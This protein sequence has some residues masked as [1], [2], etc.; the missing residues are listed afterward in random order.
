MTIRYVK[1]S[2][3]AFLVLH[4]KLYRRH[5]HSKCFRVN[6]KWGLDSERAVM[7]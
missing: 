6:G 7:V 4:S 1:T 2:L 3:L 5:L